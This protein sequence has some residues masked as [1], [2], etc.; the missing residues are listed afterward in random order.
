MK[1]GGSYFKARALNL[2]DVYSWLSN[3]RNNC[4]AKG[5]MHSNIR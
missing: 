1:R 5:I 4:E 3:Q 2:K